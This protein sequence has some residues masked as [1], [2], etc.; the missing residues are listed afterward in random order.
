MATELFSNSLKATA[1]ALRSVRSRLVGMVADGHLPEEA[2]PDVSVVL[3]AALDVAEAAGAWRAMNR[4]RHVRE[5][6]TW[7]NAAESQHGSEKRLV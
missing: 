2:F 5:R 1:D 7:T 4:D 3:V 6:H